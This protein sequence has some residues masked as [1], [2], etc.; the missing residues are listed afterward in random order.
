MWPLTDQLLNLL[1]LVQRL[2]AWDGKGERPEL[3][4]MGP[5]KPKAA[6]RVDPER[7]RAELAKWR[8]GIM[9]DFS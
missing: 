8:D 9:P 2:S 7:M 6:P 1:I 4:P 3:F 5:A